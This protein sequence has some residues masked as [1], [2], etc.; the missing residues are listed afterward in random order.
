MEITITGIAITVA[1]VREIVV[2]ID[3]I[4][5]GIN[6]IISEFKETV[7]FIN[8]GSEGTLIDDIFSVA[9]K[10]YAFVKDLVEK[11][12]KLAGAVGNFV[13]DSLNIDSESADEFRNRISSSVLA[14]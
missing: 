2:N 14:R 12:K 1:A 7:E 8:A 6:E 9:Q 4:I 10:L 5:G 11:V 13:K 3:D